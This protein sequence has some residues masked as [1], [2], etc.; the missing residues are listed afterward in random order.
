VDWIGGTPMKVLIAYAS[1]EGQTRKIADFIAKFIRNQKHEAE[2][3]D[4]SSMLADVD[5]DHFDKVILAGSVHQQKHQ[6]CLEVFVA[7]K[8]KKLNSKPTMFL[9]VSLAAAFE[10]TKDQAE[11]YTE[12]FVSALEWQP[13]T[14]L[15][16]GGAVRHD[17]YGFYREQ[18]LDHVVLKGTHLDDF[19]EDKEFTDWHGLTIAVDKFLST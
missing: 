9:S 3:F 12:E 16:V 14:T 13:S 17:E 15:H 18:I 11:R 8:R 5:I 4:T 7:A 19:K 2:I 6:E 10:D 1:T